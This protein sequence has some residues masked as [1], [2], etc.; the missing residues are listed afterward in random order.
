MKIEDE[1][2]KQQLMHAYDSSSDESDWP[3]LRP[4]DLVMIEDCLGYV[5][6]GVTYSSFLLLYHVYLA[7]SSKACRQDLMHSFW[8]GCRHRCARHR[9]LW[10]IIRGNVGGKPYASGT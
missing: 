5:A 4:P 2:R 9:N 3:C 7:I 6:Q 10:G 8:E 1:R